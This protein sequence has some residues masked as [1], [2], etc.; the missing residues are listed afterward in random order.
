MKKILIVSTLLLFS[1]CVAGGYSLKATAPI[2]NN[3]TVDLKVKLKAWGANNP[4]EFETVTL[5]YW[6]HKKTVPNKLTKK[7]EQKS[8]VEAEATF[9]VPRQQELFYY[10]KV[11]TVANTIYIIDDKDMP[12]KLKNEPNN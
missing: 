10:F 2:I 11:K 9:T 5:I 12:I 8:Q 7:V 4:K 3:E 1:A 6:S